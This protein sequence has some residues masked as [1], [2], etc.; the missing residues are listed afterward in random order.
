MLD[1]SIT[2]TIF[3]FVD[4]TYCIRSTSQECGFQ[5]PSPFLFFFSSSSFQIMFNLKPVRRAQRITAVGF[6]K[7]PKNRFHLLKTYKRQ[8]YVM[9]ISQIKRCSIENVFMSELCLVL[10]AFFIA[11]I[12]HQYWSNFDAFQNWS[13]VCLYRT[14]RHNTSI[15]YFYST[16]RKMSGNQWCSRVLS[17]IPIVCSQNDCLSYI[18]LNDFL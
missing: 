12:N 6:T 9:L 1:A 18:F 5:H 13:H 10:L 4:Q 15:F 14:N 11:Y 3:L 8:N 2:R 7:F 17:S 16:L